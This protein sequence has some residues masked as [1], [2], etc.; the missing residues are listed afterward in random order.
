MLG[1][2][3]HRV[4]E[5]IESLVSSCLRIRCAVFLHDL[6]VINEGVVSRIIQRVSYPKFEVIYRGED[7]E[8]RSFD[9]QLSEFRGGI[10]KRVPACDVRSSTCI[11]CPR[12]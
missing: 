6:L 9:L 1:D 12:P 5:E 11:Q 10:T 3:F 8:G 4:G 7:V 2:S